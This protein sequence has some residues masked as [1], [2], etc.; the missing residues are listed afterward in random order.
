MAPLSLRV[1]S[2]RGRYRYRLEA[3]MTGTDERAMGTALAGG[4]IVKRQSAS[5]TH[6]TKRVARHYSQECKV[7]RLGRR[8]YPLEAILLKP[9]HSSKQSA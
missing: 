1:T 3:V 6:F 8:K 7:S 5:F 9:V 2:G 4:V